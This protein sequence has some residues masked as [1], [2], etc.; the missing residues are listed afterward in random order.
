MQQMSSGSIYGAL[1]GAFI[2]ALYASVLPIYPLC[3]PLIGWIAGYFSLPK[4]NQ[5]TLICI[6]VVL[7]GTA[8]AEIIMAGQ[9]HFFYSRP[10][11]F[12]HL[13]KMVLP[14]GLMNALVAPF[15]YFPLR[16][17]VDFARN[18]AIMED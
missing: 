5:E 11:V 18:S 14:E 12:S 6:P 2:A 4:V 1:L 8:I 17:W 13:S 16:S 9:L 7:F 15:I 3:Y 10:D